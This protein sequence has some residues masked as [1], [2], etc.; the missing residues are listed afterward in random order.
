MT[1]YE[2]YNTKEFIEWFE[3]KLTP[4][5]TENCYS[6]LLDECYGPINIC[7]YEY[8][9]SWALKQIDINAYNIG[10]SDYVSSQLEDVWV[11]IGGL[12]YDVDEVSGLWEEYQASDEVAE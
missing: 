2:K 8:D 7:G 1:D 9:A 12:Y 4:I 3:G 6:Y 10:H 11:K 5:D